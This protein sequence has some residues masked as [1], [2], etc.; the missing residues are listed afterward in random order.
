MKPVVIPGPEVGRSYV[1]CRDGH[2]WHGCEV[3]V[4]E[5]RGRRYTVARAGAVAEALLAPRGRK[6]RKIHKWTCAIDDLW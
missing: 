6:K 3:V 5:I 1:F 2:E 4:L